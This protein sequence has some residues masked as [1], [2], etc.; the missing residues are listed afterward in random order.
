M[1][2]VIFVVIVNF[3]YTFKIEEYCNYCNHRSCYVT[4]W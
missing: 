2:I 4:L 3:N 1:K